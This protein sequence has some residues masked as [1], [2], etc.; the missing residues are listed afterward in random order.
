[1]S[2]ATTVNEEAGRLITL[3][4]REGFPRRRF[5]VES[6]TIARRTSAARPGVAPMT[7]ETPSRSV[8]LS[9]AFDYMSCS[10]MS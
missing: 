10:A 8:A 6:G 2:R 4:W 3:G 7:R 1:M 5:Q 9:P